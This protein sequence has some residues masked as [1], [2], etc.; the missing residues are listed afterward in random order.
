MQ[1]QC[2]IV[3]PVLRTAVATITKYDRQLFDMTAACNHDSVQREET[4]KP[5]INSQDTI[6]SY[7]LFLFLTFN[8][9][10]CSR[11]YFWN[12]DNKACSICPIGRYSDTTRAA[13]CMRCP[14]Y[15]ST[16][17]EGSTSKSQ[18][19]YR[20]YQHQQNTMLLL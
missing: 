2:S 20:E 19:Y 4:V 13:R 11:G 3:L 8:N 1:I 10:E 9:L 17:Q 14:T 16:R 15:H 12:S 7:N 5:A 6:M 18:C